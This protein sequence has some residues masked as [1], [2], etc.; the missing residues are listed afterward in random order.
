MIDPFEYEQTRTD[1]P[2]RENKVERD[3][4]DTST[5]DRALGRLNNFSAKSQHDVFVGEQAPFTKVFQE[6]FGRVQPLN[7]AKSDYQSEVLGTKGTMHAD[8]DVSESHNVV[9]RDN[10][11]VLIH[12]YLDKEV[13]YTPP[14]LET[15]EPV[16][17]LRIDA[18]ILQ[19]GISFIDS[20][21]NMAVTF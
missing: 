21:K 9:S 3:S 1:A 11:S 13:G 15:V 5:L 12:K 4:L 8:Y 16:A 14:V 2:I 19:P 17:R 10:A 18:P 6:D 20:R 7:M